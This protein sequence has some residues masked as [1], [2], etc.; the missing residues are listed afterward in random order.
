MGIDL[1]L[2]PQYSRTADFSRD[3]IHCARDSKMFEIIG[4]LEKETGREIGRKGISTY[5]A[6]NKDGEPCYGKT[7]KT[8]YGDIIKGVES[9]KLKEVLVEYK[10]CDWRNKAVISFLNE[11][12]HDLEV[13]LYWH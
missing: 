10:P 2:L 1:T 12:P 9:K 8:P 6:T 7:F 3:L 5:I 11:L 4:K 13:W